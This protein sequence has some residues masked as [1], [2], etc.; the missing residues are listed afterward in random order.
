MFLHNFKYALKTLFKNKMLIFWTYA[1]PIFLGLFF[2]LAF[3]NIEKNEMLDVFDIAV[4]QDDAFSHNQVAVETFKTLSK[5]GSE[6]QLFHTKYTDIE[7]A[8]NLLEDE[9][10]V[11]YVVS[12]ENGFKVVVRES[13]I[14]ETILKSVVDEIG[15]TNR[16]INNYVSN[17]TAKELK[18]KKQAETDY[19]KIYGEAIALATN[20]E[21][22]NIKDISKSNLSY[23]MIEFYTLI[24]M[25][26]LY[27][28]MIGMFAMNQNLPNMTNIGKRVGVSPVSKMKLVLSSVLAGYIVQLIG[29]LLLFLCTI[30]VF[31]VDYGTNLSLIIILAMAGALAGLSLG[32]AVGAL[33]KSGENAK[34]GIMISV[35]MVGCFLSGMMGITMK[36][37]IDTSVPILNKI[38]PAGMIT[39]G[40]Y[41]L[42]YYDT[43]NRY[44]FDVISLLI[45][46]IV[47]IGLAF[48][49]LRRQAYDSI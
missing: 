5:D 48:T 24:A 21:G 17:K 1:F 13:G 43:L 42:Y 8:K 14:N 31:D 7:K 4:V 38:N 12:G 41:S 34:V 3:S 9:E 15:E 20:R 25:A 6:N 37:V 45:F 32:I 33:V 2:Y 49:S 46:S 40:F 11:G 47:M 30:F 19:D 28:G 29:L 10:I 27:G 44:S 18:K 22:A 39:D 36:Y 26:C 23:T 16:L 35:T